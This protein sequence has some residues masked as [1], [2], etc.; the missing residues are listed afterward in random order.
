[1]KNMP[2]V[3]QRFGKW[4]F[5]GGDL[6]RPKKYG[7]LQGRFRCECGTEKYCTLKD[8]IAGK[9]TKCGR[10][11]HSMRGARNHPLYHIWSGIHSRC[12]PKK[13][14]RDSARYLGKG[15]SIC[16]RWHRDNHQ[17]FENF[18]NDM[19]ERPSSKHSIDR[20]DGTKDYNPDNCRWATSLVQGR[21]RCNVIEY[22]KGHLFGW[23]QYT[24]IEKRKVTSSG[25][26]RLIFEV[27]C[28]CR[29]LEWRSKSALIGGRSTKCKTCAMRLFH[30]KIDEDTY[31]PHES[32]P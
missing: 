15:I 6:I 32:E 1:M 27:K 22:D 16:N 19:G 10:C 5:L 29:T 12:Y 21:N 20:I 23:W 28:R 8:V 24:G 3:N 7:H 17:G 31:K 18:V 30:G 14:R 25:A 4:T 2:E 11:T 26:S 9:S 13:E